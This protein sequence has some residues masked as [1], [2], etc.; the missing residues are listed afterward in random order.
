MLLL[1]FIVVV[2][3]VVVELQATTS[4]KLGQIE[5]QL[6]LASTKVAEYEV[7]IN[8]LQ[9]SKAKLQSESNDLAAQLSEAESK[10]GSLSKTN[11]NLMAQIEEL[12]SELQVE[13]TV[14]MDKFII[15]M[16][17]VLKC[18]KQQ[19]NRVY[20]MESLKLFVS[21]TY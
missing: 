17:C 7:T 18:K 1:L 3:V 10:N 14:R 5:E 4:R 16:Q 21:F 9:T 8:A 12:K 2:V 11:S 19:L 15:L 20:S 6:N 13:V